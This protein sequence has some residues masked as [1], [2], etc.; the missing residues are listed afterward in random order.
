L[1]SYSKIKGKFEKKAC[2]TEIL[3]EKHS[4]KIFQYAVQYR[5]EGFSEKDTK[6]KIGTSKLQG[7]I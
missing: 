6:N 2:M 3:R 5:V 7:E 4:R 1:K